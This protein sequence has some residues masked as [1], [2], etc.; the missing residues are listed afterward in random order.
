MTGVNTKNSFAALTLISLAFAVLLTFGLV[1]RYSAI[2]KS[3][4]NSSHASISALPAV[5]AS[6][7]NTAIANQ[8]AGIVLP[9]T[10]I[11]A[12][13]AN[14]AIFVLTPGATSFTRLFRVNT[15]NGN[16]IGIDFRVADGLLYAVTD[17]GSIYTINLTSSKQGAATLVSDLSPRFAGGF[18]SLADFNPVVNALRLIGTNDQNFAVVNSSGNL[19]ATAVQT[20]VSY[21]DGDV[22]AGKDP[23][24][25]AGS[26]TNNFVGATVTLFYGIDY[27]LDT[28]V[29]IQPAA[30]GGS[31]ATGGGKLQTIGRLVTPTGELVN[32]APTADIDIYSDGAG[33]NNLIGV[34][35]RTLFTIDLSKI[36]PK[37]ALGT[38]QK[39]VANGIMMPDEGGGFLDIAVAPGAAAPAPAP[40]PAPTPTPTPTPTPAAIKISGVAVSNISRQGATIRWQT[41][42]PSDSQVE[43]GLTTAYGK[44]SSL[45]PSLSATHLINLGYLT[46]GALYHYRVRSKDAAG[47]LAV[48]GD[49]TFKTTRY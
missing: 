3:E 9:K 21:I 1:G 44:K 28:L 27:D 23:N 49:F 35:G 7:R 36:D 8:S 39:V 13:N 15:T 29:T 46:P 45:N 12:L 4:T 17:T 41:N 2:A 47:N 6:S 38:T 19:N 43:F 48:S 32:V 25:A 22:N 42:T 26:Y 20:A 24:I 5:N 31:S 34:S 18:Q 37:L 40:A 10:N 14:N 16:L 11:Y 33:G 30:P